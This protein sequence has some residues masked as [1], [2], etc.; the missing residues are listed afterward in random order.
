MYHL[1]HRFQAKGKRLKTLWKKSLWRDHLS[2]IASSKLKTRK[3]SSKLEVFF[4]LSFF[5][6]FFFSLFLPPF[7][8]PLSKSIIFLASEIK[9]GQTYPYLIR[10]KFVER[11]LDSFI[12]VFPSSSPSSSPSHPISSSESISSLTSFSFSGGPSI[13]SSLSHSLL[14]IILYCIFYDLYR[15]N[16]FKRVEVESIISL[17]SQFSDLLPCFLPFK[18]GK[19][20][21]GATKDQE[22]C[23]C[24]FGVGEVGSKA[25]SFCFFV[26]SEEAKQHF[27]YE[28]ALHSILDHPN[29]ISS[30]SCSNNPSPPLQIPSLPSQTFYLF[31]YFERGNLDLLSSSSVTIPRSVA[32]GMLQDIVEGM[33][34]LHSHGLLHRFVFCCVEIVLNVINFDLYFFFFFIIIIFFFC[35]RNLCPARI[36]VSS[37]WKCSLGRIS[38]SVCRVAPFCAPEFLQ[39]KPYTQKVFLLTS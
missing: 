12:S 25:C 11:I 29:I 28:M 1:F 17:S 21:L 20:N 8:Q 13:S 15:E 3:N 10:E 18:Y 22:N 5:F 16:I 36:F 35:T 39:G 33:A 6:S 4:L 19:V 24:K 31:P 38:S 32:V 34:Y 37:N 9:K 26:G 30:S 27:L 7:P 23:G 2:H 14:T